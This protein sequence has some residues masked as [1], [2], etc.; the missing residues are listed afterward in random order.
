MINHCQSLSIIINYYQSLSIIINHYQLLS[1]IINNYQSF[2]SSNLLMRW[3]PRPQAPWMWFVSWKIGTF[4][5][6]VQLNWENLDPN[7]EHLYGQDPLDCIE[8][9]WDQKISYVGWVHLLAWAQKK[10]YFTISAPSIQ[11]LLLELQPLSNLSSPAKWRQST[12]RRRNCDKDLGVPTRAFHKMK[13][14]RHTTNS[15]THQMLFW[16]ATVGY[17]WVL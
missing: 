2:Q 12:G 5:P 11:Y 13:G 16:L 8:L 3:T 9:C 14:C 6:Q 10:Q 17:C 7:A 1:I 4:H 15:K